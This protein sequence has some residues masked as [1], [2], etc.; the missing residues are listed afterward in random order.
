MDRLFFS[1]LLQNLELSVQNIAVRVVLQD[2][3]IPDSSKW[4]IC[5]Q[6]AAFV[7]P[8]LLFRVNAFNLQLQ[9]G[10]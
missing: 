7:K 2:S 4:P 1:K 9:E 6:Q 8:T 5:S 10:A 3:P